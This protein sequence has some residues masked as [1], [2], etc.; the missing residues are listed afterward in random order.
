MYKRT[1][2]MSICEK[3]SVFLWGARQTGKSTLLK[4]KFPSAKTYDLLLSDVYRRLV[5]TPSILREE[6]SQ[7]G[8]QQIVIDEVQKVPDLLDE[9]HWLIE[10]R[11]IRFVL[12]GSSARKLRRHAGNLLGGRAARLELCPLVYPEIT[13]F[14][15]ER[16]LTAGLLPKHYQSDASSSLLRSYVGDYLEQEIAAE[17]V[18]RNIPAFSRFLEIAALSNGEIVNY[19]NIARE[20]GVSAPTAAGYFQILVDTLLG[21][22]LPAFRKR[23]KRRL[24]L[25]PK[26]FFFDVGVVGTLTH[27]GTVERGSEVFGRA[28]EHFIYMELAAHVVYSNLHY[29]LTYWRTASQFEVDFVM[30]DHEVAIEVKSAN[31]V[32]NHHLKGLRAFK[33]EYAVRRCIC[34]SLDVEPRRTDDGIEILPWKVFLEDLWG[35]RLM[36]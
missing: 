18:T 21:R 12:C 29:P 13:N 33:E 17:A 24:I 10:N 5:A 34:V 14:S 8:G 19:Q 31:Q 1:I 15:L 30:G 22:F 6:N 27:R 7:P 2:D 20:C 28:L 26:F 32:Q 4:K 11:G 25:A 36:A 3:E 23:G 16:A 35:G 9:V